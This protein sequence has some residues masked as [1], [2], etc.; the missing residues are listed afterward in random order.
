MGK[1]FASAGLL[2]LIGFFLLPN[3]FNERE[4][5]AFSDKIRLE[6]AQEEYHVKTVPDSVTVVPGEFYRRGG[7]IEWFLGSTYRKLWQKEV[8]VPVLLMDSIYGGL[9]PVE[10]S[11]G[12]QTIGIEA[13]DTLG[14]VWSI[15]SVNKDQAKALPKFFQASILRPL[16]RDQASSLNPYGSLVAAELAEE[17]DIYHGNPELYFFPYDSTLGKYNKRMAGRLVTIVEEADEDWA[18]TERFG[19]PET[20]LDTD[21]ML[22]M[23]DSAIYA[24]D[25]LLYARSRL[26][27][28]L[29]SDWDRHEGNWKWAVSNTQKG[30]FI[31]P[32]PVDRD[33]AFYQYGDGALNK[34]VL[35]FID[36]FQSFNKDYGKIEGL[37]HQAEALDLMILGQLEKEELVEQAKFIQER[38]DEKTIE[39]AFKNYPASVYD[40]IGEKHQRIFTTRLEKLPEVAAKFYQLI[41]EEKED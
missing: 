22:K 7:F 21:D 16:F 12:Q 18:H 37:M 20:I 27:D 13:E 17:I 15:R 11:G 26:F 25:T 32:I 31:E 14:R 24:I 30:K 35:N 36:K 4:K 5:K 40:F 23:P 8:S 39:E 41:Q 10:F 9:T 34:I 2:F 1:I 33:M 28:M 29:I 6:L 38:L 3:I 19:N